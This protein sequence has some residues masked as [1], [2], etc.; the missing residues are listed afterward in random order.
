MR[1]FLL[2]PSLLFL[3]I[4]PSNS[5]PVPG[6]ELLDSRDGQSYPTVELA[7]TKWMARNLNFS[8]PESECYDNRAEHCEKY[9]RLYSHNDAQTACPEGWRLPTYE[10]WK[11]V[12]KLAGNG[13]ADA[14]TVPDEWYG[15]DFAKADNRLGLDLLPGGRKDD[16][17]ASFRTTLFGEMGISASY[18][19]DDPEYHWHIRWGKNQAHKHGPIAEQGRKFS[20]RCVC[21]GTKN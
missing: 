14:L 17:G 9:G 21:E 13:K 3:S 19:L 6:T 7:G 5:L 12:K 1:F 11:A 4:S 16:H 2:F 10:D 15:K 20:I 8:A 18:W